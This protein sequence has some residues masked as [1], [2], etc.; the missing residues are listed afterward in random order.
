MRCERPRTRACSLRTSRCSPESSRL[1]HPICAA[2]HSRWS[3]S[4]MRSSRGRRRE[5]RRCPIG[6]SR[7]AKVSTRSTVPSQRV[8]A[9]HEPAGLTGS[10]R[11]PDGRPVRRTGRRR[12][13]AAPTTIPRV[14][15]RCVRRPVRIRVDAVDRTGGEAFVAAAAQ[16]G[17]DHDVGSVVEDRTEVGRACTQTRIAVDALEHLDPHGTFCHFSLRVRVSMRS[18]RLPAR[19]GSVAV[20]SPDPG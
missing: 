20:G 13:A 2:P 10:D 9:D 15:R 4:S 8:R 12:R 18:A 19:L 1:G 11:D 6:R 7:S 17:D 14:G 3:G 16:L 5:N